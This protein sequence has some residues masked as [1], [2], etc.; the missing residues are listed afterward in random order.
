MV[1]TVMIL[2]VSLTFILIITWGIRDLKRDL[3]NST[4]LEAKLIGEYC[5]SPLIFGD[6]RGATEVL[7]KLRSIPAITQALLYNASDSLVTTYPY[8]SGESPSGEAIAAQPTR[9]PAVSDI[10]LQDHIVISEPIV[11]KDVRYGTLVLYASTGLLKKQTTHL[12][13]FMA[14]I[15]LALLAAGYFLTSRLER[16]ISG[17][18]I[19]LTDFTNK[20]SRE[21]NFTL[22][23]DREGDDEIGILFSRFNEML[24]QIGLREAASREAEKEVRLSNEK[25]S[26]ILENSPLGFL[27]YTSQ[28]LITTINKGMTGLFGLNRKD[29]IHKNLHDTI[30]D[31]EMKEAFQQSLRG[32]PATYSGYYTSTTTGISQYIRAIFT[33]LFS[34]EHLVIGGI[35]IFEDISEQKRNEKLQV[36]KEAAIF[37]NKA[38]SIFLANMSHEIRTPLNAIL[39][40]SQLMEKDPGLSDDQRDNISTINSS[41]KH[42]LALIN[43]ILEM[44]KIEA[45]RVQL[46]PVT[47]H[48]KGLFEDV[49]NLFRPKAR[50]KNLYLQTD[51]A[52]DLPSY[53]FADEG[54]IRQILINLLS[55]AIKFT[56]QGGIVVNTH[57]LREGTDRIILHTEVSDT[58]AGIAPDEME[59]VFASF[60]QTLSGKQSHTGTGLGLAISRE[61]IRMMKGDITV[62]SEHGKGSCFRF[63]LEAEPGGNLSFGEEHLPC[64]TGLEPGQKRFKIL[65]VD[66]KEPNRRLLVKLLSRIGFLVESAENGSEAVK[67]FQQWN[68]DLILMHMVMPVMDGFEAIRI[69]RSLP[70]GDQTCLVAVTASVFEEDKQHILAAG[71]DEFIKKPFNDQEIY[72]LIAKRLGVRFIV[73]TKERQEENQTKHAIPTRE[74]ISLL[75]EGTRKRLSQA[76]ITGDLEHMERM[77][78]ILQV[79]YPDQADGLLLLVRSFNFDKLQELF[80]IT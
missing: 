14:G 3:V 73:G 33:P 56:N 65:V 71:A 13:L 60:E 38:K 19:R 68:P 41:G 2:V 76:I 32:E 4:R 27:H 58:G 25:L 36:E 35:G 62:I 53:L 21:W 7:E 69:I 20:I 46:N 18:I 34:D 26:L 43:N 74:S 24:E 30:G 80:D 11:Y 42:L 48:L 79:K 51:L 75:P 63:F 37:A 5:I 9:M 59:K 6:S 66:D 28:G 16:I 52:D 40:F 72:E 67:L 50:E 78:R 22:R 45:G 77:I 10:L 31:R 17:P 23:I 39:G 15:M 49:I 1:L 47:F 29:L 12:I 57:A 55:N 64:I 44:S 8:L 61:Y 54:K 70:G